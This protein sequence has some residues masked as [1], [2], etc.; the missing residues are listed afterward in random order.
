MSKGH[1]QPVGTFNKLL[2]KRI[3]GLRNS[4]KKYPQEMHDEE[5]TLDSRLFPAYIPSFCCGDTPLVVASE[6]FSPHSL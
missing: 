5:R 4:L 6:L 1:E 2:P 3:E